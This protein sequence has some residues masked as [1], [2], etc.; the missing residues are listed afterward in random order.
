MSTEVMSK[1]RADFA[2]ELD[3]SMATTRDL[4]NQLA[5][6]RVRTDQLRGAV[7]SLELAMQQVA[8]DAAQKGVSAAPEAPE[9]APAPVAPEEA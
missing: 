4:E 6:Q 3:K 1:M 8:A 7:Y 5:N 9:V 2:K